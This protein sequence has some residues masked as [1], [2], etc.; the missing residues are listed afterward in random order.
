MFQFRGP[1]PASSRCFGVPEWVLNYGRYGAY[2]IMG[3]AGLISSTVLGLPC[4]PFL[5]NP[6]K[7]NP[8]GPATKPLHTLKKATSQCV[9]M[10]LHSCMRVYT[11]PKTS[12]LITVLLGRWRPACASGHSPRLCTRRG[13]GI[14]HPATS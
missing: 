12:S 1:T 10:L 4:E 13:P 8:T 11:R 3:N 14:L 9:T 7:S 2:P 5:V 6:Q